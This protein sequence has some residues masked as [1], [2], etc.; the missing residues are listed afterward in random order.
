MSEQSRILDD[1]AALVAEQDE[2]TRE[3]LMR[4]FWEAK[5]WHTRAVMW[6]CLWLVTAVFAAVVTVAGALK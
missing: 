5:R 3:R 2:E 6:F 1:Y 4:F